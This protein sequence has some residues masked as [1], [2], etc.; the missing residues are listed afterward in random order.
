MASV[1][2]R[3][4]NGRRTWVARWRDPEGHQRK[5]SFTKRSD[6]DRFLTTVEHSVLIGAYVDPARSRV[7]VGAW[8][9][10]WLNG[11]VQLKASTR[12]RYE[13]LLRCQ[14]LPFWEA[15]PLAKVTHAGVATWVAQLSASGLSPA[16]VRQ[17]YRVMSLVLALAVRDGRLARNPA[18]GARLPRVVTSHKRFLTHEQV[19]ALAAAAGP[20]GLVV[21][22]LAYTGLRFGELAALRVSRLDLIRRRVNVAESVTEVN[23]TA[24]FGTPKSHQSRS[25]PLPRCLVDELVGRTDGRQGIY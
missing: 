4:R 8:S 15:V 18:D 2:K 7:T 23:G 3:V 10:Q 17:A 19:A 16:T 14:V 13:S 20:Y 21:E 1:E 22:T 24:V 12:Y 5:R 11:Q 6:A 9:R 25:V